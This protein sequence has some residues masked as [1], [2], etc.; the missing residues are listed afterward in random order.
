MFLD[1]KQ[2][3]SQASFSIRNSQAQCHF[4]NLPDISSAKL[5]NQLHHIAIRMFKIRN[6]IQFKTQQPVYQHQTI[7]TLRDTILIY[8]QN[9]YL[10]DNLNKQI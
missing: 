4:K 1:N 3:L 6:R 7:S 5:K 2:P 10:Q 9:L 8:M